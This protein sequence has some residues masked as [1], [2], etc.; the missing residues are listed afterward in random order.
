MNSKFI[1]LTIYVPSILV[2]ISPIQK[3]AKTFKYIYIY[4]YGV[5][6]CEVGGI[7]LEGKNRSFD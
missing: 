7:A 5:C 3:I 1:N 6:V 2:F 4:T